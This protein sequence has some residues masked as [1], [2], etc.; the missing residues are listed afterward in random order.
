MSEDAP[1]FYLD[2]VD[3]RHA[4]PRHPTRRWQKRDVSKF[5]GLVVH[6]SLGG[7]GDED[8]I[9]RLC[10]FHVN[11]NH[12][13]SKGLPYASYTWA[14]TRKGTIHLLN[15][16]SDKV[17]S[18]G[19]RNF[20]GDEN[21]NFISVCIMGKFSYDGNTYDEPSLSQKEALSDLWEA[22]KY[23]YNFTNWDLYGHYHLSGKRSC[24]G[25]T[26]RKWVE[27]VNS[28]LEFE[29]PFDLDTKKGR[30]QILKALG[31]YK[32]DIDGLWGRGSRKAL[33]DFQ[34]DHDYR[35]RIGTWTPITYRD[36]VREYW[37]DLNYMGP[38]IEEDSLWQF[39]N[40]LDARITKIS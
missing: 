5:R 20:P 32:M 23:Y 9:R 10:R 37:R 13:S 38:P 18:H 36:V 25:T 3:S 31:Y 26:L 33:I 7:N 12:I 28:H 8:S 6:Q 24:P 17:Y 2:Y 40:S 4:Y 19:T 21:A 30:Q 29:L 22:H 39:V 1:N 27:D 14:I 11:S 35:E 34:K 16:M 15:D